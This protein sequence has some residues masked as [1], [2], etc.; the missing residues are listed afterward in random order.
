MAGTQPK[1]K[2]RKKSNAQMDY[3]DDNMDRETDEARAKIEIESGINLIREGRA[4]VDAGNISEEAYE[5]Y[6]R[7]LQQLLKLDKDLPEVGAVQ[8]KIGQYIQEA[9]HLKDRLEALKDSRDHDG[10]RSAEGHR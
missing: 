8:K 6:V 3:G 7:G 5:K 4:L 1:R 9:E 2:A 10:G